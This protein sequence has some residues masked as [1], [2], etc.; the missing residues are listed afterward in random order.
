MYQKFNT[1]HFVPISI[2][3]LFGKLDVDE[4]LNV[5]A[6]LIIHDFIGHSEHFKNHHHNIILKS[7]L[8]L[9]IYKLTIYIM[10][11]VYVI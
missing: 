9:N 5:N 7:L 2:N 3:I 10:I 11:W 1:L 8:F 6:V 4:K